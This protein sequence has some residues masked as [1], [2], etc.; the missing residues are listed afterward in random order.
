MDFL[1]LDTSAAEPLYRQIYTRF[2]NAIAEGLLQ[3]G[4]RI[5][6][7]RAL[8]LELGLARGTVESAYGL[9]TA[10]GYVEARGQAGT[11]V[12]TALAH[13]AP[14]TPAPIQSSAPVHSNLGD[15]ASST[16]PFQMG[17][18]ALD[19]FP[20]KVWA[21]LAAR[22]IRATQPEHMIYPPWA[23]LPELRIAIATYLQLS[24]G[25]DCTPSQVFITNGY[26]NSMEL[27][28]R[29]LLQPGDQAWVED[30]GYPP[31]SELLRD[32]GL[33]PV[34]VQVDA[35]GLM[36]AHGVARAPRARAAIVTPAHQS[37]LCVSLSLPRRLALLDWAAQ[38]GAWIV[39]DDYDGEYRY[40]SRPLPA[41]KS[42]DR[43]GR[44]LY[45][46]T[47]SKVLFPAIRLAYLVV[48]PAQVERF[49]H[50]TRTFAAAGPTLMQH[51]VADFMNEGH[52]ARHIQ[53][54]RRLYAERRQIAADG[55]AAALGQHVQVEP[56]PGG[57]HLVLRMKGRHTDRAVAARM[58]D[59]G[60][61]A[62]ALSER[63]VLPHGGPALL[64][65]F[66]NIDTPARA[67]ELGKRILKIMA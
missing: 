42:L 23:G 21:R 31:T 62:L 39:E 15:A 29:A 35:E 55:L 66:T 33:T 52:F 53:R 10:E 44:V 7:A 40:V 25:I 59:H 50:I 22:A 43:D 48:P 5:P 34:P 9:L 63:G 41:L 65:A 24:R 3:P 38:A 49:E 2:R 67:R 32:A 46:G 8:A 16:R 12:T 20:R 37:P 47:F 61:S 54:M 13:R 18:P 14:A 51:I 6:A 45:S 64:L 28:T 27:V 17:I 19:V 11:V 26:R 57:M 30:P 60:M 56:Q 36:V 58:R 1:Q 4:D